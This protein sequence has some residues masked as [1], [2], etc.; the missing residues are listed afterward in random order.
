MAEKEACVRTVVGGEVRDPCLYDAGVCKGFMQQRVASKPDGPSRSMQ[1]REVA[2]SAEDDNLVE[3]PGSTNR[4]TSVG[5]SVSCGL[6]G[7]MLVI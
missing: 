7:G 2:R 3:E 6:C 1:G 4:G 5:R